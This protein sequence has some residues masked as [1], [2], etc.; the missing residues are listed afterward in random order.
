MPEVVGTLDTECG[1]SRLTH[2]SIANNHVI[3]TITARMFNALG[4]RDVEEGALLP[5]LAHA[6]TANHGC[7]EDGTGRGTP[8]VPVHA[9][10]AR[11][12]DVLQYGDK[13]GP[14][15]TDGHSVA[16]M[17]RCVDVGVDLYNQQITYD[18]H[19]PLRTAGGH[20]SPA[21][22]TS[23]MAVRRLTPRECERLQGFPDDYTAI[24]WRGRPAE[25]CADGPRYKALGNS[26]AVPVV[27]WIG[28]RIQQEVS[29]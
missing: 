3:G 4:A 28:A 15:D 7:T 29:K 22:L 14:L 24:R 1:G 17:T 8:L 23:G 13:T 21:A 5:M 12:S 19:A 26:W 18:V 9:F 10:D 16:V 25:D 11:Q 27:R 20:G 6:L 2:Q